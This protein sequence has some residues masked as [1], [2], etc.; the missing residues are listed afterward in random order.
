MFVDYQCTNL[1]SLDLDECSNGQIDKYG[2]YCPTGGPN[3]NPPGARCVN[4]LGGFM[5]QCDTGYEFI[6]RGGFSS[7]CESMNYS[8]V[9]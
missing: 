4:T 6:D 7:T 8:G 9:C 1:I 3:G 2:H 5:C